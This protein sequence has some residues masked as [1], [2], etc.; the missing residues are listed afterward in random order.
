VIDR[1]TDVAAA[2]RHRERGAPLRRQRGVALINPHIR[3]APDPHIASVKL[4]LRGGGTNG[5]T[6]I[7]D[8]SPVGRST[9]LVSGVSINTST[10]KYGTGAIECTS[11]SGNV[12][13]ASS[14]DFSLPLIYTLELWIYLSSAPPADA[15]VMSSSVSRYFTISSAR[16]LSP[17]GWQTGTIGACTLTLN[18]WQHYALT[19]DGSNNTRNFLNGSL[20]GAG[21]NSSTDATARQ[22]GLFGVPG[23]SDLRSFQGLI[24]DFR[25]TPGVCRYTSGFT[26]PTGELP[27]F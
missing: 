24:D 2:L 10:K 8:S 18:V 16:S 7:T 13:W 9:S 17:T 25:W 27:N 20:L 22:L 11:A 1:S 15:Y 4:L 5:S 3:G 6:T 23:R 19:R 21:S 12:E 14:S 26:P